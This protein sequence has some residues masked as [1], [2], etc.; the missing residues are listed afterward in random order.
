MEMV[1]GELGALLTMVMV[2]FAL[3][4]L[5][6]ANCAENEVAWPEASVSGVVSPLM[7]KPGPEAVA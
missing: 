3:P 4:P 7:L 5:V 1:V 2:P 6:G